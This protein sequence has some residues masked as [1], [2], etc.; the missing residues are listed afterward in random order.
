MQM[1]TDAPETV[2]PVLVYLYGPPAAGKPTIAEEL[3]ELTGFLA[4]FAG[5]VGPPS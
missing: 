3:R 4:R 1:S 2:A 5:L